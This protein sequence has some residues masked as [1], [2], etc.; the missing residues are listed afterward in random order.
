MLKVLSEKNKN[1]NLVD[2]FGNGDLLLLAYTQPIM[3]LVNYHFFDFKIARF[4]FS[5]FPKERNAL[6]LGPMKTKL[7]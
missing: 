7:F 5:Y 6:K 3:P 1:I 4:K 2:W